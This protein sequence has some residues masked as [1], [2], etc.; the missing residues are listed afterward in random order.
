MRKSSVIMRRHSLN[1]P[2]FRKSSTLPK[3]VTLARD[4]LSEI[5][6]VDPGTFEKIAAVA[7]R[8]NGEMP[9]RV[10][11]EVIDGQV[12]EIARVLDMETKSWRR[13]TPTEIA[14]SQSEAA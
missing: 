11:R 9:F 7:E 10:D 8:N 14:A 2:T 12:I 1:W 3:A 13:A 5:I 6:G 4:E